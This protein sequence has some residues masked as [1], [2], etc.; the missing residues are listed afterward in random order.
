MIEMLVRLGLALF[1][2]LGLAVL[3]AWGWDS[4]DPLP[5]TAGIPLDASASVAPLD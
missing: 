3:L 1:L 2:S 5:T 4:S